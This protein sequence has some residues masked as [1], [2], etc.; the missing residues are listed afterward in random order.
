MRII[1]EDEYDN[2]IILRTKRPKNDIGIYLR[3]SEGWL[4]TPAPREEP[5]ERYQSDGDLMPCRFT[6]G[7]RTVTFQVAGRFRS[8]MEAADFIDKLNALS[9]DT[10]KIIE[11][12]PNGRRFCWGYLSDDPEPEI[13]E[14]GCLVLCDLIFT[15]PDPLKYGDEEY[16][17]VAN[18]VCNV[19]NRG[20]A[21][22]WPEIYVKGPV[23]YLTVSR[24]DQ[25]VSWKGSTSSLHIDFSSMIPNTGKITVDNAFQ[26]LPGKRSIQVSTDG[27]AKVSL[28]PAW[29]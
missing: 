24:G 19:V 22:T 10:L 27:V 29:R 13:R 20:N 25:H 8:S 3:G 9:C 17:A 16:F 15:C 4:G 12:G 6:Q 5:T 14:S 23:T 2:S 26:L 7:S 1:I 28:R 21:P 11:E 18:G